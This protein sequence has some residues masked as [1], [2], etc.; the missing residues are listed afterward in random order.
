MPNWTDKYAVLTGDLVGFKA[1]KKEHGDKCLAVLKKSLE[2]VGKRYVQPFLIFRG[3]SFQ[4]ITSTPENALKDAVMLR[5]LLVK[6]SPS[7][8]KKER[9]DARIAVGVGTIDSLPN[10]NTRGEA[11]GE[12]FRYSG[13]TLD[14][15]TKNGNKIALKTP[16]PDIDDEF[17]IMCRFVDEII[18][19]YTKKQAEVVYLI[20]NNLSQLDISKQLG[21]T[22]SGVSRRLKGTNHETLN[23]IISRYSYKVQEQLRLPDDASKEKSEAM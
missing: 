11:D 20:F 8:L 12:A 3:D 5:L 4:G 13:K 1:Q 21:I 9:M 22:Q 10:E 23:D 2:I 19:N 18:G 6:D 17:S 14:L 7:N 16:W 15:M